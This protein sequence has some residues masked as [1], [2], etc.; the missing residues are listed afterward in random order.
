MTISIKKEGDLLNEDVD[1]IINTVNCVGV[2]GKGIAL[3]FKNKWPDNYKFYKKACKEGK[4]KVGESLIYDLGGLFSKPRYIVNFPTKNHWREKSKISYIDNGLQ[5][6]INFIKIAGI[7][8]IAIPPL[9]CGNGGLKWSEVKPIIEKY[10][11][12]VPD[13]KVNLFEPHTAPKAENLVINT[14]KPNLTIGRAVL[15]KILSIYREMEY[16]LSKLEIQKLSY[17]GQ[18]LGSLERLRFRKNKFGPYAD[19][20]RH[21]LNE[22]NGH[23]ISGL[24]DHDTSDASIFLVEGA[25]SEADKYIENNIE[26]KLK[27]ERLANLI[28]G[29]E[30]P[31]G[32]ELLATVHWAS[33]ES[34]SKDLEKIVYTVHNW[35]KENPEW[36]K[37]KKELMSASHIEVAYKRL[38]SLQ[39]LN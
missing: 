13:V 17:F 23:Y 14:E 15:I 36:N 1:A 32:M 30:S 18:V 9:G 6:L 11:E 33:G 8:S 31:Y 2:M 3:Q 39:L 12:E 21:V 19:N 7:K 28:S 34:Q 24:G 10:F 4:V 37:R 25:E 35:S 22:M 20:L 27:L 38:E 26:I 5:N 29:F 16:S